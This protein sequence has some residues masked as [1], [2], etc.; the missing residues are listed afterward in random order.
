MN[1]RGAVLPFGFRRTASAMMALSSCAPEMFAADPT[2]A[3][4]AVADDP[5]GVLDAID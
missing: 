5:S 4:E 1:Q 2:G 3:R